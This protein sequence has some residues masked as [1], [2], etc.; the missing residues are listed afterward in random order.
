MGFLL[1]PLILKK[2]RE[3][4]LKSAPYQL[5]D[6]VLF[7]KNYDGGFLRCLENNQTDGFLFQFHAGPGGGNFSSDTMT[8]RIIRARYYWPTLFKDAQAYVR[9]CEPCQKY[10]GKVKKPTFPL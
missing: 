3:L 1:K 10:A 8:H 6:N 7:R 2:C 5:I 4:R 9:R